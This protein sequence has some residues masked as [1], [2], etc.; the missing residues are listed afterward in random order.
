[1]AYDL[2]RLQAIEQGEAEISDRDAVVEL[3]AGIIETMVRGHP[4]PSPTMEERYGNQLRTLREVIRRLAVD[5]KLPTSLRRWEASRPTNVPTFT[6]RQAA[7]RVFEPLLNR[8]DGIDEDE[9]GRARL[10]R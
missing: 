4:K 10:L 5:A 3:V 8:L 6:I 1:V 7:E 9:D 2:R